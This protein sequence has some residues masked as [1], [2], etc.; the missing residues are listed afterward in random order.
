M[1]WEGQVM[2]DYDRVALYG[3]DNRALRQAVRRNIEKF[4]DNFLYRLTEY[5]ANFLIIRVVLQSFMPSGYNIGGIQ[6]ITSLSTK[7]RIVEINNQDIF[8]QR[9]TA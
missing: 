1:T 3:V 6:M 7:F 9:L 8:N 2:I 4:P 5:G